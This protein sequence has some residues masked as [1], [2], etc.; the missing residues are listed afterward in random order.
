M[1]AQIKGFVTRAEAGLVSPRSISR[2][3]APGAGGVAI[4][5]GGGPQSAA[6]PGS[7]HQRCIDTWRAWQR[8]H[9]NRRGFVDVAYTGAFC[10][11][12]FAFAGRGAGIRTGANGTNSGNYLYYA[13]VWIGGEGQDPNQLAIDA[14]D[15]WLVNLRAAGAGRGVKPHRF[16]KSTGCP[17]APLAAYASSRDGRHVPPT[18]TTPPSAPSTPTQNTPLVVRKIQTH[19]EVNADGKWG[20]NTD[21]R[22]MFMRGVARSKAGWPANIPYSINT[23]Q[24][25]MAQRVIDTPDD[26]VWGSNSQAAM[27]RWVRGMQERI[28]VAQD[29]QWGPRTDGK[30]LQLR[31]RYRN[32]Y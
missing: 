4:H 27:L 10:N 22:V 5:Y 2:S 31:R 19:V 24:M 3:I 9:M 25:K 32:N 6:A 20:P 14:A 16:F 18:S 1:T 23:E 13:A 8:D 30:L 26:G 28:G 21:S 11:H 29:G 17:G 12:G 7:N 15:W